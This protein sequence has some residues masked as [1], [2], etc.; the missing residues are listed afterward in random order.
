[1]KRTIFALL[2]VAALVLLGA[3]Q[4]NATSITYTVSDTSV[5]GTLNGT[6]FTAP[7]TVTFVGDTSNVLSSP[8]SCAPSVAPC[9]QVGT[10]TVTIGGLG[11]YTFTDSM[12]AF[13]NQSYGSTGAAGISDLTSGPYSVLDTLDNAFETYDLT[14]SIGPITDTSFINPAL[15]A[16]TTGGVLNFTSDS[17]V[18]T[19]TAT[20]PE[21]CSLF[22]IGAG[23][24]G[25][26][27]VRRRRLA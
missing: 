24:S 9:N 17:G 13:D 7:V 11:T 6:S 12:E 18:S 15:D 10:A 2:A 5:T 25:L 26:V 1:M 3:G 21:P 4:A 23:L 8:S 19:F 22:L 16:N 27:M 14:T 20:T